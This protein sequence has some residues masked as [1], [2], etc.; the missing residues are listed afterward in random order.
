MHTWIQ[1]SSLLYFFATFGKNI[2]KLS[3]SVHLPLLLWVCSAARGLINHILYES[4]KMSGRKL[5]NS[6]WFSWELTGWRDGRCYILTIFWSF[7]L[8]SFVVILKFWM[9]TNKWKIDV[10]P[11]VCELYRH[12]VCQRNV[13]FIHGLNYFIFD[14]WIWEE[15]CK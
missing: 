9:L 11:K 1:N 4:E 15:H 8:G 3:W 14:G 13:L 5:S 7:L 6:A 12:L 2:E 10:V